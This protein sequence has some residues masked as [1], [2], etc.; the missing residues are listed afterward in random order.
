MCK[1]SYID[2]TN[3]RQPIYCKLN[4]RPCIF[5]KYCDK[6][7]KFVEKDGMENC[8]MA[9]AEFKKNVPNGAHYVRFSKRG[10]LFVELNDDKVI[11]VRD[12]IGIE[13]NYVYLREVNGEYQASLNPFEE[14]VVKE[15]PKKRN[16]KTKKNA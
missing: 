2:E 1:Y 3:S 12:T 15:T 7:N 9:L 8:F 5:S 16:T 10:F 14:N 11:M 4:R 13:T 6:V